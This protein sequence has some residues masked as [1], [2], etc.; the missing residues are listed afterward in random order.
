[1]SKGDFSNNGKDT[2]DE[3]KQYIGIRLQQGVP[4]LDRDWNELEDI[5]RYFE[6]ML[7][8]RYIGDGTPDD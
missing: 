3:S 8:R 7:R 4:L 6:R 2:F 1:M 5:R